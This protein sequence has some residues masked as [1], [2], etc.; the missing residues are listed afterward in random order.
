MT[1]EISLVDSSTGKTLGSYP[2][3]GQSG[4]SGLAGGTSEAV[5][6]TAEAVAGL[7][8]GGAVR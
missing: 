5:T 7:L 3:T 1:T 2:V 8:G 6:K 4:G